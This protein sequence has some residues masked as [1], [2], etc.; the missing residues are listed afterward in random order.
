[1]RFVETAFEKFSKQKPVSVMAGALIA[2]TLSCARLDKIF[3]QHADQQYNGDLLFS[4]VADLMGEV[5]LRIQPSVN[6][7][8]LDRKDENGLP[9]TF[10]PVNSKRTIGK[11]SQGHLQKTNETK[12]KTRINFQSPRKGWKLVR[13]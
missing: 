5:V 12:T 3:D 2:N 13:K 7:A 4:T 9:E 11:R 6:A 10:S 1:M 8:W